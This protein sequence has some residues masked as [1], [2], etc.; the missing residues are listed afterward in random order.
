MIF[1]GR[2]SHISYKLLL[3]F[4]FITFSNELI[5]YLLIRYKH[6]NTHL[7]YN[8]YNY[9]RFPFLCFIF[10]KILPKEKP[11][12]TL[13]KWFYYLVPVLMIVCF[14]FNGL[15]KLHILY[16]TTGYVFLIFLC[17]GF[18]YTHIKKDEMQNPLLQPFFWIA[19]G[20]MF[21]FLGIL[22][23]MVL[24]NYLVKNH[25]SIARNYYLI[26]KALNF[27]LYMLIAVDYIIQWR[28]LTLKY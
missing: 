6:A 8:I 11:F 4:L 9:F 24:I 21:Y 10:S 23:Y 25:M 16:V 19:T 28:K 17:M 12:T 15:H 1:T 3:L 26:V 7:L 13:I 5:A 18:F 20:F 27:V 2:S 22:P 14:V